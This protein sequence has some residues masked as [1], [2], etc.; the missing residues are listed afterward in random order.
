MFCSHGKILTLPG[1]IVCVCVCV[2]VESKE[3]KTELN[4]KNAARR[5]KV[6]LFKVQGAQN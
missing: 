2:C 5:G 3:Y 6:K 1:P 4:P